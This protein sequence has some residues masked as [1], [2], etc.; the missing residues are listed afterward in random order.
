MDSG[1]QGF[2]NCVLFKSVTIMTI[3]IIGEITT[4]CKTINVDLISV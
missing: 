1:I 3:L 4:F 2:R